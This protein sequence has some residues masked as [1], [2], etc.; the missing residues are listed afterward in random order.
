MKKIFILVLIILSLSIKS[1][2]TLKICYYNILDFPQMQS[3][4]IDTLSKII[5]Y[6]KPDVFAVNELTSYSGG[7]QIKNMMNNLGATNYASAVFYDGPDTDNL[8]FY[9]SDKLALKSQTQIPT[10]LRDISE[11]VLYYKNPNFPI[12]QDTTF[13]YFYSLHLK[14][15]TQASEISQRFTEAETLKNYF[16]NNN[17][18]KNIILGGDFNFYENTEPGCQEILNGGNITLYDPVNKMGLWHNNYGYKAY[19]TQSTRVNMGYA[20]GSN[21]GMDDRF[22]FIFISNDIFYGS[23]GLQYIPSSYNSVGQDGLHYNGDIYIPTNN[24]VPNDIA[25]ALFYMSDHIPVYMEVLIGG[26]VSINEENDIVEA[27]FINDNNRLIIKANN[28]IKDLNLL[29]SDL[30]GRVVLK[31][32]YSNQIE[33]VEDLNYLSKG[34]YILSLSSNNTIYSKKI[35]L[36]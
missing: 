1:Q 31:K 35:V 30:H 3:D 17:R 16:N 22:D 24:S 20:G 34:M 12:V 29:I 36:N 28:D 18:N 14:A 27:V 32:Q 19:H 9:N 7:V 13:I 25:R 10:V 21:G 8:L 11:Y 6:I 5:D 15:G 2:D 23:S 26:D 33:I 4:R